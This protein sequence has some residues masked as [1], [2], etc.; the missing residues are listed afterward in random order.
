MI[1]L[2]AP[3]SLDS[4]EITDKGYINQL[5]GLAQR[6]AEVTRLYAEP[7]DGAVIVIA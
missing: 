1:L 5:A 3:P 6:A 4:G 2:A 7:P